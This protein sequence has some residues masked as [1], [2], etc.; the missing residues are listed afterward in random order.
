MWAGT[1]TLLDFSPVTGQRPAVATPPSVLSVSSVVKLPF[2]SPA[3]YPLEGTPLIRLAMP[4]SFSRHMASEEKIPARPREVTCVLVEDQGLF[5]ELLGG[6]LNM[7]GG[8]RVVATARYVA[9]GKSACAKHRPDLLLLDLDLPDGS[10]LEVAQFLLETN[11]NARVLIV[12]GHANDFVCPSWLDKSLQAIISKN[13]TFASLREEL[14]EILGAEDQA[15]RPLKRKKVSNRPLTARESEIFALVG[16][17]LTNKEI[18]A[19]LNISGH[20]VHT[21][22]KRIAAKL[23]T[24]GA[25]ILQRAI[26]QRRSFFVEQSETP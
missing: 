14:D 5:L 4:I 3:K 1:P 11:P 6:M 21:H 7:Y 16:D 8:L 10:G 15:K 22:R 23:G 20:T 19:R 12:S 13:D 25:E 18:G 17:G 24:N 2:P 9:E 26:V